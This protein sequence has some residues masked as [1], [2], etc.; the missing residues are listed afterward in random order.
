M[1]GEVV[2]PG[3]RIEHTA[4]NDKLWTGCPHAERRPRDSI[5]TIECYRCLIEVEV[6]KVAFVAGAEQGL[7]G[8]VDDGNFAEQ[9]TD[10]LVE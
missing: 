1:V 8:E 6:G 5:E 10:F 3:I 7:V 9:D 4:V 2:R